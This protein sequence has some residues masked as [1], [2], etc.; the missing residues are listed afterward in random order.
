MEILKKYYFLRSLALCLTGLFKLLDA[1]FFSIFTGSPILQYEI[2]GNGIDDDVDGFVG[3]PSD[4]QNTTNFSLCYAPYNPTPASS[5]GMA[6]KFES[7]TG[8]WN[9]GTPTAG[10]LNGDAMADLLVFF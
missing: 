3:S 2:C 10:D 9:G 8:I 6:E 4:A 7:K 5:W 1:E